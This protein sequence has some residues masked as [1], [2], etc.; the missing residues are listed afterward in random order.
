MDEPL[1]GRIRLVLWAPVAIL[2]AYEAYLSSQ[3]TLPELPLSGV[4]PDFD[5]L[6]HIGYFFLTGL[7]GIRAA[8]FG[9]LWSRRRTA[10]SLLP[11]ALAWGVLDEFHQS[12]VPGRSVEALD[13]MA[14]VTGVLLAILVAEPIWK[15]FR[16]DR[17]RR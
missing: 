6:E 11:A 12:F 2:L 16:L 5:K 3:S 15:L 17:V 14:D 10:L 1:A 13:V 7:L 4:L 9:E 8:R